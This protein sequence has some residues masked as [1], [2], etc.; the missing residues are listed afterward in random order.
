MAHPDLVG[1]DFR[2]VGDVAAMARAF[3]FHKS[4]LQTF[5]GSFG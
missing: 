1:I 5:S 2:D 4:L 3:D